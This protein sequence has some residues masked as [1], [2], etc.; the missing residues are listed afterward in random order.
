MTIQN[1]D[2]RA[3]GKLVDLDPRQQLVS[4]IWGMQVPLVNAGLST[5][6]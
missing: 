1:A 4:Q 5:V 3:P 6:M 2:R